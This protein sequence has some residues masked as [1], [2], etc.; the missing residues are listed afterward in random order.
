MLFLIFILV[1]LLSPSAWGDRIPNIEG[2]WIGEVNFIH[3]LPPDAS[4]TM[5]LYI[6]RQEG[7]LFLGRLKELCGDDECSW[8]WKIFGTINAGGEIRLCGGFYSDTFNSTYKFEGEAAVKKSPQG[9]RVIKGNLMGITYFPDLAPYDPFDDC[10]FAEAA[11]F[12]FT[13]FAP[14]FVPPV[15]PGPID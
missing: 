7:S 6:D 14:T 11:T 9:R 8:A 13:Q 15:P 12:S 5:R 3:E 10:T 4:W 2:L 1:F